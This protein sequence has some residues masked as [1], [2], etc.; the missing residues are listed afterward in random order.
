MAVTRLNFEI[1][2][3]LSLVPL[4]L[5]YDKPHP[6]QPVCPRR[7][8]D[9]QVKPPQ[10]TMRLQIETKVTKLVYP[11][12]GLLTQA[13]LDQL[14]LLTHRS[15]RIPVYCFKSSSTRVVVMQYWNIAN[16]YTEQWCQ[17]R[18]LCI[19]SISY[20]ASQNALCSFP[21]TC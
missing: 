8:K 18:I 10:A 11:E 9:T 16:L 15:F 12:E 6:Q 21:Y 13:R 14:S 1:L 20:L 2:H 3:I 19:F 5:P 7:L 4:L 17:E